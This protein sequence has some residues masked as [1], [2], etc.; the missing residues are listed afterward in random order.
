MSPRQS[1]H[2]LSCGNIANPKLPTK[3]HVT[4]ILSGVQFPEI[5]YVLPG[6]LVRANG[7]P[8]RCSVNAPAC[9]FSIFGI[10]LFGAQFQVPWINAFRKR[11]NWTRMENTKTFGDRASGQNVRSDVSANI[12]S[13]RPTSSYLSISENG[14]SSHPRPAV[15]ISTSFDLGPKPIGKASRKSLSKKVTGG[16]FNHRLSFLSRLRY[17]RSGTFSLYQT[18]LQ[19]GN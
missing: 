4:E 11:G 9:H 18:S 3:I 10:V 8:S 2:N 6:E 13:E 19:G 5:N 1:Q 15:E 12:S 7:L 14:F 17:E 16:N